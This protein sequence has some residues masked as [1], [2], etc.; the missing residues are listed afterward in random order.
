M[1]WGHRA[2]TLRDPEGRVVWLA[3]ILER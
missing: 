3:Q 2:C 1:F